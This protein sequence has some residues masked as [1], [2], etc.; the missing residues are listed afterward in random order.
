MA[1]TAELPTCFLDLPTEIRLAILEYVFDAHPLNDGFSNHNH[2]GGLLINHDYT[3]TTNLSPLL[4]CRQFHQDFAR[5]A[6]S[7]TPF[8]I[9]DLYSKLPQRL[10]LLREPH[11]RAVRSIAVVAGARQI[12]EMGSW[13]AHPFGC[14]ELKLHTLTIVL[15][16][17]AHWHY[18]GDFTADIV[19]LLRN[20]SNVESLVFVRNGANVK[21]HFKTWYNRLIGLML[22]EDHR[23][24]FDVVPAVL[25][26]VWWSWA[27]DEVGQSFR[28]RAGRPKPMMGEE[29]YMEMVKPLVEE[30]MRGMEREEWDPDPRARN[31]WG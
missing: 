8:L 5:L 6:I 11:Q 21:G 22:K 7:R 27:F 15:H 17:S 30:L 16:R 31:G 2:P 1:S 12:R 13:G 23:W 9:T 3:A 18:L 20:L 28:L 29:G 19:R 26:S 14:P 10:S 25:E 4:T 24:R